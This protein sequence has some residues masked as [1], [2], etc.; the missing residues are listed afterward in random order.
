MSFC[1]TIWCE[2]LGHLS[3][4]VLQLLLLLLLRMNDHDNDHD[5]NNDDDDDDDNLMFYIPFII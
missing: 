5:N 2:I 4:T 3:Y 1:Q